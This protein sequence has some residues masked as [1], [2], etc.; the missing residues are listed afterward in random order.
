VVHEVAEAGTHFR[1]VDVTRCVL[2]V[3]RA[4]SL[5]ALGAPG[6]DA[7]FVYALHFEAAPATDP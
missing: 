1:D 7:A 4:A 6:R 3:Y 2:G 5:P